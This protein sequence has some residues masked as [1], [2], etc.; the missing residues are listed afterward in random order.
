[1]DARFAAAGSPRGARTLAAVG[2]ALTLLCISLPAPAAVQAKTRIVWSSV[3]SERRPA[4]TRHSPSPTAASGRSR[5]QPK[6]GAHSGHRRAVFAGWDAGRV[7]ARPARRQGSAD[8]AHR[9]RRAER[10]RA[11]PGLAP[12]PAR[13]TPPPRGRRPLTRITPTRRVD[14]PLRSRSTI[15]P[16]RPR[17]TPLEPGRQRPRRLSEPG[18][19]GVYEDNRPLLVLTAAISPSSASA[20]QTS[21]GCIRMNA[22]GTDIR[23]LTPWEL[24]ADTPDLSLA[25]RG[26]TRGLIV[27]QTFGHGAPEG[28]DPKPRHGAFDLRLAERV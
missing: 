16:A 12:T 1:M 23:Q 4:A 8:R 10:A 20:T 28:Q 3:D 25:N 2:F 27:F 14:R 13:S 6:A 19:D 24:D 9:R 7:R 15:R 5:A 17:C 22:D 11:R 18:I 26:P 21:I